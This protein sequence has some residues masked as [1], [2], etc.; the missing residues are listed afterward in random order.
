MFG[1]CAAVVLLFSAK[2]KA[3]PCVIAIPGP[4]VVS[5]MA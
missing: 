4:V 5:Q 1:V 2:E 3:D